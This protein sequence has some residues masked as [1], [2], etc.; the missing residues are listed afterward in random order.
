MVL[1]KDFEAWPGA[2]E[3]GNFTGEVWEQVIAWW[4]G[5]AV[6]V[7]VGSFGCDS[8]GDRAHACFV[9]YVGGEEGGRAQQSAAGQLFDVRGHGSSGSWGGMVLGCGVVLGCGGRG[10]MRVMR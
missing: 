4:H 2:A 8:V 6:D 3:A 7:A 10:M 1:L 9:E 5:K